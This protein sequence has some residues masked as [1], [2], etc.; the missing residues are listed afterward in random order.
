[1]VKQHYFLTDNSLVVVDDALLEET[2]AFAMGNL[3]GYRTPTKQYQTWLNR[4]E[5]LDTEKYIKIV[6]YLAKREVQ[7]SLFSY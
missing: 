1:M 6:D 7:T 3:F 2:L 4:F 5:H